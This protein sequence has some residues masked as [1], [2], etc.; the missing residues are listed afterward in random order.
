MYTSFA[1]AFAYA[2]KQTPYAFFA[3]IILCMYILY[4]RGDTGTAVPPMSGS[5]TSDTKK[6]RT[7]R[8]YNSATPYGQAE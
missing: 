6:T 7:R 1:Y 4:G 5:P 8:I 2:V 3:K